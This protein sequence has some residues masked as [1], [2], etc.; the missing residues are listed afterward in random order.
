[1]KNPKLSY[2]MFGVVIIGIVTIMTCGK[3]N[4]TDA[5]IHVIHEEVL[6]FPNPEEVKEEVEAKVEEVKEAV[7]DKVEE[8]KETIEETK[9][10]LEEKIESIL[11]E[12]EIP[13][14]EDIIPTEEIPVEAPADT[15]EVE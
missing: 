12:I 13:T 11:P 6:S 15:L 14:I 2:I 4:K 1:M 5:P 10:I 3:T 9:V 7:T 8:I